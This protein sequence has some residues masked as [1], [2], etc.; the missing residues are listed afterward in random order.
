MNARNWRVYAIFNAGD[1][2]KALAGYE[3]MTGK[4]PNL[5]L[6]SGK[7]SA[8]LLNHL[9]RESCLSYKVEG[10]ILPYDIWLTHEEQK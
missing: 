3:Q 5:V 4:K 6:V 8:E 9:M 7:A 10:G 2:Q 1:V